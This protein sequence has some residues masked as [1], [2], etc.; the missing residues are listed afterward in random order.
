MAPI[1]L[2]GPAPVAVV[3]GQ[4]ATLSVTVAAIPDAGYQ[5]F[6]NGTPIAG[7]TGRTLALASVGAGDAGVYTV[8]ATNASGAATS[9]PATLAVK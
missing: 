3:K 9:R 4:A 6:R 8:T 1:V 7:A 2:T 5:W